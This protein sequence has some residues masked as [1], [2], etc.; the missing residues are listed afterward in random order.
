[1]H[2]AISAYIFSSL[3]SIDFSFNIMYSVNVEIKLIF[4]SIQ[5]SH[6]DIHFDTSHSFHST[7]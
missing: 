7:L 2:H 3:R 6:L 4:S 1:M 5:S